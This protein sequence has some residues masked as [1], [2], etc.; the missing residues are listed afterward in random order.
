[1]QWRKPRAPNFAAQP[2][3]L[4]GALVNSSNQNKEVVIIFFVQVC[5]KPRSGIS[6]AAA[7]GC[8]G[9]ADQKMKVNFTCGLWRTIC[10]NGSRNWVRAEIRK[11]ELFG[12]GRKSPI[13]SALN[14]C[15]TWQ[16]ASA[17]FQRSILKRSILCESGWLIK[18][19]KK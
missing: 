2:Q 9:V 16:R 8:A 1:M 18:R 11:R 14:V 19:S 15:S 5:Q 17:V 7:F 4:S 13:Q 10:L 12:M 3:A 6:C